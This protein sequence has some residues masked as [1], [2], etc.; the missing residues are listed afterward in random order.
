MAPGSIADIEVLNADTHGMIS[1]Q[2]TLILATYGDH[3]PWAAPVYYVFHQGG[4]Y[5]FSSPRAR[6]IRHGIDQGLCAGAIF[7]DSD[8]WEGIRGL[9][10]TGRMEEVRSLAS[11]AVMTARFVFKF[12]FSKKFLSG[13]D[14][15]VPDLGDRVRCYVFT[16]LEAFIVNNRQTFGQR[17][18]VD[19][20]SFNILEPQNG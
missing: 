9:Q 8:Q 18:A 7:A 13:G 15:S 1:G 11:M 4:F 19:P 17:L 16:P 3:M 12:P 14:V 10:M 2:R 5:F 20:V 6:H